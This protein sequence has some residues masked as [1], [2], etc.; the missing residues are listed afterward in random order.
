VDLQR[1]QANATK[2]YQDL[3]GKQELIAQSSDLINRKAGES[4]DVLDPLPYQ[5][6]RPVQIAG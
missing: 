6:I 5:Q 4:L 1:D 2:R 3:L